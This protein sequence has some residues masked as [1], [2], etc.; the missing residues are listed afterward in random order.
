[1]KRINELEQQQR[2]LETTIAFWQDQYFK[3]QYSRPL[4]LFI[5]ETLHEF[6]SFYVV[7]PV[8]AGRAV[9]DRDHGHVQEH[10]GR[11]SP[12]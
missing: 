8:A 1:M 7:H 5:F 6:S 11:N 10:Y 3:V 9:Q 12:S 2:E 4:P